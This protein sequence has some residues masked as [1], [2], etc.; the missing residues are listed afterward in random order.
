MTSLRKRRGSRFY[1]R[2]HTKDAHRGGHGM[3]GSKAHN[4]LWVA[5]VRRRQQKVYKDYRD[6][7]PRVLV[8]FLTG[9]LSPHGFDRTE[10][11]LVVTQDPDR[12]LVSIASLG[13]MNQALTQ[14][15]PFEVRMGSKSKRPVVD[16]TQLLKSHGIT[17][18]SLA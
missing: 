2:G 3:A 5:K 10:G 1:G 11:S 12:K 14:G 8:S 18:I 13:P 9:R 17:E 16:L 7:L 6:S 4:K 15:A